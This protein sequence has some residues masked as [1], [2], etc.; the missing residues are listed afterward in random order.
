SG[1][2]V[3]GLALKNKGDD[4]LANSGQEKMHAQGVQTNDEQNKDQ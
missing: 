1:D 4:F 2:R 3:S